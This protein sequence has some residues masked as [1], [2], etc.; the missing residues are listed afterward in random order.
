MS[1]QSL[2][3]NEESES[4]ILDLETLTKKYQT[5]LIEYQQAVVN[6]IDYVKSEQPDLSNNTQSFVTVKSSAYWGTSGISQNNSNSL[7]KCMYSCK[8]TTGCTGATFNAT[9]YSA[10]M[11]FLRTGSSTITTGKDGDYAIINKGQYL[12]S[13]VESINEQLITVNQQILAKT[14]KGQPL[15]ESNLED[16]ITKNEILLNKYRALTLD[17]EKITEMMKEYQTLDETQNEGN[18]KI[19]QNYYSFIL[20]LALSLLI[21]YMLYKFSSPS[22]KS[23]SSLLQSGGALSNNTYYIVFGIIIMALTIHFYKAAYFS[24]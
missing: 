23:G 19:N 7:A 24:L 4:I 21:V 16:S 20:L 18:I 5:I 22:I 10:P 11:C 8:N 13:I 14:E 6:Y 1:T 2:T 17:R 12:L 3:T 15:H 9:D